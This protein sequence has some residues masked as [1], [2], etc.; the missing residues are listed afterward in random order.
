MWTLTHTHIHCMSSI[1]HSHSYTAS[2]L[3]LAP[4]TRLSVGVF[5][6]LCMLEFSRWQGTHLAHLVPSLVHAPKPNNVPGSQEY[7]TTNRTEDITESHPTSCLLPNPAVSII[8]A[9]TN[10]HICTN[11]KPGTTLTTSSPFLRSYLSLHRRLV[12]RIALLI[13]NPSHTQVFL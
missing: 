4:C 7:I 9:Y 11:A 6:G 2:Q 13:P 5:R 1:G 10:S 12:L 8:Y 3:D